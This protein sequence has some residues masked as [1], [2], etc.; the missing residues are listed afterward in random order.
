M[1]KVGG[2]R[3]SICGAVALLMLLQVVLVIIYNQNFVTIYSGETDI[4]F[5]SQNQRSVPEAEL[6]P[7]SADGTSSNSYSFFR[8]KDFR[9]K[10]SSE[11]LEFIHIPKTGGTSIEEAASLQNI[12]W[13]VCHWHDSK[14]IKGPGC[15]NPDWKVPHETI[16]RNL[17]FGQEPWHTPPAWYYELYQ[18]KTLFCVV[19]N[20]Y[21]KYMSDL[22]CPWRGIRPSF[23]K[24]HNRSMQIAIF[25][26][27]LQ[28]RLKHTTH[29]NTH[30]YLQHKFVF[31]QGRQIVDHVLHF[32][33]LES[34][35]PALMEAYDMSHIQLEHINKGNT[36]AA[37]KGKRKGKSKTST[38]T[39]ERLG[40]KE[41]YPE[42]IDMINR[43]AH[44]DF[45]AFGYDK[46]S[47]LSEGYQDEDRIVLNNN[48]PIQY[49]SL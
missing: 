23:W 20:P 11:Q 22:Y 29:N 35:F 16:V 4:Y 12:T 43:V 9:A 25:N 8:K 13:G 21:Y 5:F 32:E 41:L 6:L 30:F 17:Y 3:R 10:S 47:S 34:E 14:L 42:T 40:I 48:I 37:E 46:L 33:Q 49:L 27:V 26:Q 2:S 7:L 1:S 45:V 38:T 31:D 44:V 19:R 24:N 15:S 18:N 39:I 36:K 28:H